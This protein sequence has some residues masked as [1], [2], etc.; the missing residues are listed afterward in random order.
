MKNATSDVLHQAI[1]RRFEV[2]QSSAEGAVSL[3]NDFYMDV[4]SVFHAPERFIAEDFQKYPVSIVLEYLKRTHKFYLKKNLPELSFAADTMAKRDPR[5]AVVQQ[6]FL[7]FFN[8]FRIKLEK[9]IAEEEAHLFP[10]LDALCKA[11]H[12]GKLAVT[13]ASKMKLLDFLVHH[14]DDLENEL[15]ELV[16]KIELMAEGKKDSFALKMMIT[17]LNFFELDLRIHG[18]LEDEVLM[19]LALQLEKVVLESADI[20]LKD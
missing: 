19:P 7:S 14:N 9:H 15:Q 13:A 20:Q 11:E 6:M 2:E 16:K 5:L 8:D 12:T 3:N 4:L 18:R 1:D 10:Y 17:R